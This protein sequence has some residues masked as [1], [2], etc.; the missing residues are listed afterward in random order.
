LYSPLTTDEA[1]PV[2]LYVAYVDDKA[3]AKLIVLTSG[4]SLNIELLILVITPFIYLKKV[5][6]I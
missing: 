1:D 4:I 5:L 6:K 3:D 2:I